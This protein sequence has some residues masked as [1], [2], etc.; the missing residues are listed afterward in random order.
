M[1]LLFSKLE[2]IQDDLNSYTWYCRKNDTAIQN[3]SFPP[4]VIRIFC[5]RGW[6]SLWC[7]Y[8]CSFPHPFA[9][10]PCKIKNLRSASLV[11]RILRYFLS[12]TEFSCSQKLTIYCSTIKSSF[13]NL[14]I[15]FSCSPCPSKILCPSSLAG[16][17]DFRIFSTPSSTASFSIL[18]ASAS[19][20]WTSQSPSRLSWSRRS[21]RPSWRWCVFGF[22][23][24]SFHPFR[25]WEL[26]FKLFSA[27]WGDGCLLCSGW[28]KD[29]QKSWFRFFIVFIWDWGE[30]ERIMVWISWRNGGIF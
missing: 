17:S 22:L 18:L 20:S 24:F 4:H 23:P 15:H 14:N 9:S 19:A 13:Y 11:A 27:I 21:F 25:F 12:W 28:L 16:P 7:T 5:S 26:D 3:I 6:P 2:R 29:R 1:A 30:G 10:L 8:R